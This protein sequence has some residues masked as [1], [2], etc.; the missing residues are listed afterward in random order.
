MLERPHEV[1][2]PVFAKWMEFLKWLLTVTDKIPKKARFTVTN[3]INNLAIDVIEDLTEARYSRNKATILRSAN[4][5]LE[6]LRVL[7]R[8]AFESSLIPMATYKHS[9]RELNATGKMLGGWLK[10]QEASP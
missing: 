9:A 8:I 5:K 6:K 1:E 7:M 4:I 2:L 10:Q 3:R